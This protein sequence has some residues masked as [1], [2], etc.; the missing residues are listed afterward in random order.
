MR[1]VVLV[2]LGIGWLLAG[3]RAGTV[4]PLPVSPTA[5]P[6][7]S[8]QTPWA[9]YADWPTYRDERLGFALQYPPHWDVYTLPEREDAVYFGPTSEQLLA[10]VRVVEG[11]TMEETV[12]HQVDLVEGRVEGRVLSQEADTLNGYPGVRI[13][14][15]S[16]DR[17]PFVTW[18]LAY[19]GRVYIIGATTEDGSRSYDEILATF[20]LLGPF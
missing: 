12:A 13:T 6:T 8:P 1:R 17:G 19:Q 9:T 7:P 3:C 15:L 20:H 5:G 18:V 2:L 16:G 4:S 10:G 11:I 14:Y